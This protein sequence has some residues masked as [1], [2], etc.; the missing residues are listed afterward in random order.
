[1]GLTPRKKAANR[2]MP[3]HYTGGG[4]GGIGVVGKVFSMT[5]SSGTSCGPSSSGIGGG[6]VG[7]SSDSSESSALAAG[8]R[9]ELM[10]LLQSGS[11][12]PAS[13]RRRIRLGH[14]IRS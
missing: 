10:V 2:F 13:P 12:C 14:L 3:P 1:M 8:F 5:L 4:I 6:E 7:S 11:Q 9:V